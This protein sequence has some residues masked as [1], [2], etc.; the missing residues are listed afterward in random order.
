LDEPVGRSPTVFTNPDTP[1]FK[2]R[3]RGKGDKEQNRNKRTVRLRLLP[4]GSQ[5]RSC[6]ELLMLLPGY[7]M[8]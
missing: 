3:G 1:S 2:A 6:G 7:G 8:S 4:N 5:E